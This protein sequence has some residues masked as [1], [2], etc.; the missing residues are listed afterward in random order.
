MQPV[1][2]AGCVFNQKPAGRPGLIHLSTIQA[3]RLRYI[4]GLSTIA[5][6]VTASFITMQQV[7]SQQ[8]NFSALVNLA[9]HQA[10]LSN[11]ISYFI[12]LMATTDDEVEFNMARS[13]VG[14]GMNKM[15]SV[16]ESL[17]KGD[18]ENGIPLV[19]SPLLKV[20]YDDPMVGLDKAL[21][22]FLDRV[23]IVYDT[24]M[25]ALSIQSSAYLYVTT[26]GPHVLDPLLDAAVDEYE[27]IGRA[28]IVRIERLEFIIWIATMITLLLEIGFIFRPLERHVNRAIGSLKASVTELTNTR[29]RLISAQR[30]ALVGDWEL[31]VQT[32]VLTWSDQI[33]EIHGVSPETFN[34]TPASAMQLIHP[35]DRNMVRDM[36][37]CL[38]TGK[39]ARDIEYR[40]RRPDGK[41]RL[42]YQ[43]AV[44]L[45]NEKSRT[46]I[47]SG[48]V[49]DITARKEL[50]LRLERLSQHIPGFIFQFHVDPN[51]KSWFPYAGNGLVDICGIHPH[52]IQ[53]DS[54]PLFKLFHEADFD[55]VMMNMERSAKRLETWQDQYRFHHPEKGY[56][57]LE[58]HATPE[59][60]HDG[61]TD[62]YGYIWDITERRNAEKQIRELALYDPL[63]GLA[64]R[65][66]LK[67]RISHAIATSRR[68]LFYGAVLMLDLDNFK[69]LNDT[70]G[71]NV[72]DALLIEVARRLEGCV[73]KIDTI[74][75][76]GGDEFVVVLE[77]L[78]TEKPVAYQKAMDVAQKL[79]TSLNRT[80]LLGTEEQV[81]HTSASVGVALFKSDDKSVSELLKRA[82]VA[83]YEAKD[84]GRN[85][86]CFYSDVRQ[87]VIDRKSKLAH[88]LQL[89]LDNDEFS[90]YLQ[91]QISQEGVL[92]GAEALIRW[93]P[94]GKDPVSPGT[95]IPV[96]ESTGLILPIGEWVLNKACDYLL[97]LTSQQH[98]PDDFALAVNISARQFN[99]D[100]FV[101][102]VAAV[103][104][105]KG[106]D[107]RRL[108]LELTETSLVQDI[109][110]GNTI[111]TE[112]RQ[113]GLSIELDDFGTGYSSLNSLNR[114]PLDTLKIDRSLVMGVETDHSSRAIVRAIIAMA[115][116]MSL[117]VIAEGV[118]TQGQ[119]AFLVNERCDALQGFL[120]ARPMPY[121]EFVDYLNCKS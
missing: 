51:G 94:P 71:H 61:S 70:K 43:H 52:E 25:D 74:A 34:V 101:Q 46:A 121:T 2:K 39:S 32:Q 17:R 85:T 120:Y 105:Q 6:L 31:D 100:Q 66:L 18:P 1:K 11:R 76:L 26:Y 23:Q 44:A 80:Y 109:K 30:L 97:E 117:S 20:I 69:I 60:L 8:R 106:I 12:S 67:D 29:K 102:K 14:R 63:T 36:I 95:F 33:Y 68:N 59:R 89:A 114:L 50:S 47:I 57:W 53:K 7:V 75:R 83:M 45:I 98:L 110:R 5:L 41:E 9:G 73:R 79:R 78:A 88:D 90:I 116:A 19:S 56:V 35:D 86:V 65:R 84:L 104:H 77:W 42:V 111:L 112:L 93:I 24:K 99:D 10:G 107:T 96:A 16:H 3:I 82:D 64:N 115:K 54:R 62:W 92:C 28:A 108:K 22:R 38:N 113:M 91:P 13:Q 72:G 103:I 118:E 37:T 87:A 81:H 48:T 55:R 58:G 119:K 21:T 15:K 27:T 4:I 40:I 49:Q